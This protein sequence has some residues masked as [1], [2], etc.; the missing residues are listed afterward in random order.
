[1]TTA[2]QDFALPV[3]EQSPAS[4][5]ATWPN[6]LE[7]ALVWLGDRLNPIL[8]KETR[9]ALKSRQFV[10]T[11]IL[12]L[13][14]AWAWSIFGVALIGPSIR[15]AASGSYMFCGYYV[16]LAFPLMVVVPFGA[17]RSLASEREDGTYEL[18]S[19]TS[20][21]P[22]QIVSGKLGSAIVQMLVYFSAIAPCL[23]FTYMLKG[24]DVPTI[25]FVMAYSFLGSLGLSMIGLVVSTI[26]S[27]KHW[28]VLI[29]VAFLFGLA[30]ALWSALVMVLSGLQF[31]AIP[32]QS[33]E[34]WY[35]N[36]MI[37]T[38]FWS[39]FALC[40]FAASAQLSFP[41]DNRST[42]LRIVMIVQQALL[43]GWVAWGFKEVNGEETVIL[44][45]LILSGIHWAVMGA[46]NGELGELSLR[47]KRQ[48]P[49][50]F[51]GRAFLTWFNPGPATGYIFTAAN[52]LATLLMATGLLVWGEVYYPGTRRVVLGTS[53]EWTITCFGLLAF[54]Y[55]LLYLGVGRL[56]ISQVRRVTPVSLQLSF[57]LHV[58]MVLAG[59][60]IP[61]SIHWMT[62]NVRNDYSLLEIS[63]P[64][65]SL[66]EFID[67]SDSSPDMQV[68]LWLVPSAALV[69]LL[70]NLPAVVL[71]VTQVRIAKP[72]RLEQ[73]EAEQA[74]L[75]APP[76][77]PASPFD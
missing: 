35:A 10:V 45:Y 50:S 19:V 12:V 14:L 49:G 55:I 25:A 1:M 9:Q 23:A 53:P 74:A 42:R 13:V 8:V 27:E 41:S 20:L 70:M 31:A 34:F 11:F 71:A 5:A 47:V 6:R 54:S 22:R 56:L 44:V 16:I 3:A 21:R 39:Y 63:N 40:F 68:V 59:C 32:F 38:A 64:F 4:R 52:L 28:Q 66:A 37:Q 58:L 17:F 62:P 30:S 36:G 69:I 29:S 15:Y 18:L 26:T 33:R 7:H 46:L 57:L 67:H 73:E 65:Y 51:L 77:V 48:L 43:T 24:I 61:L 60:L 75:R 76:L 2:E 72:R